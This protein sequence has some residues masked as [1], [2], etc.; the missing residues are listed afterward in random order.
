L[1]DAG[2]GADLSIFCQALFPLAEVVLPGGLFVFAFVVG[3][4]FFHFVGDWV[5]FPAFVT[6]GGL[7]IW[8]RLHHHQEL[9]LLNHIINSPMLFD[10]LKFISP[11]S[12]SL[13]CPLFFRFYGDLS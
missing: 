12:D 2:F 13:L 9:R 1:F 6:F 8:R 5:H 4:L 3:G 11:G 10:L 7:E